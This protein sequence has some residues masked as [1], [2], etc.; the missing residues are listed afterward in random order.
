MLPSLLLE[1]WLIEEA[2]DVAVLRAQVLSLGQA[3]LCPQG[4]PAASK[5]PGTHNDVPTPE[6]TS[7]WPHWAASG[8][9]AVALVQGHKM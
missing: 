6:A 2:Q 5:Q 4:Q 9:P 8:M 7:D 3:D 1:F